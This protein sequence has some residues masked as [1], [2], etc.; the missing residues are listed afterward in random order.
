MNQRE[1]F[2]KSL[3]FGHPDRVFYY[4]GK[5]RKATMQAWYAQGLPPLSDAGDYGAPPELVTLTGEDLLQWGLPIDVGICPPF[6]EVVLEENEHGRVWRDGLGITMFSD[7]RGE[8]GFLTRSYVSHPVTDWDSWREMRDRFNPHS[9]DRFPADWAEQAPALNARDNPIIQV[10]Q[11]L[12]WKARDFVGFEELSVMFYDNPAL[13][14]D[15]MEHLTWFIIELLK[16]ALADVRVEAVLLS[17]DMAYKHAMMISPQMFRE[18]MLPR[19]R[20]IIAA[21]RALG[22]PLI[23]VDSDGHVGQLL[24]LWIEAGVDVAWPIEIAALND[25]IAYRKQYGSAIAFFGGIDKREIRGYE[26]TY[27][28]IMGKVPRL[29]EQGGYIPSID[30]AVPPDM[31]VRSYF[32]MVEL[33]KAIA[34]GRPIPGPEKGPRIAEEYLERSIVLS[35]CPSR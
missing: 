4:F 10:V 27:A 8:T 21:M 14:H 28:E 1:R 19:Y 33:I 6:E 23:M 5:P 2:L 16:K 30:H 20:R 34:E 13:V 26:Q 9:P 7:V 25:P 31:P 24:P 11:G 3:S 17:E 35:E 32:Y 22:V 29:L 15:M 12:Y 18:F